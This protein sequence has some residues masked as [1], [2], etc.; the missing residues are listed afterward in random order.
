MA[1]G[2]MPRLDVYK[3]PEGAAFFV[4]LV[5]DT[6][7]DVVALVVD[8]E[9]EGVARGLVVDAKVEVVA[10]AVDTKV[11]V[12]PVCL[13]SVDKAPAVEVELVVPAPVGKLLVA[14]VKVGV[15]V[16]CPRPGDIVVVA[17]VLAGPPAPPDEQVDTALTKADHS[18]TV[19]PQ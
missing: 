10:L 6:E 2:T 16:V 1:N 8:T 13:V 19:V 11:E 18:G 3:A 4:A 7:V 14:E 17:D 15:K 12:E 5:V 9:V